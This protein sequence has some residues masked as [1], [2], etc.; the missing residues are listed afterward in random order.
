MEEPA[1]DPALRELLVGMV[2]ELTERFSVSHEQ[3]TTL[4]LD[5][6]ILARQ[7]YRA[8]GAPYGDTDAGLARWIMEGSQG[9]NGS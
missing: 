8:T 1:M 7:Q 6:I 5:Y 9:W 4:A 2:G 3:A